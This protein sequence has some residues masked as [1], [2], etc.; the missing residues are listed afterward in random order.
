[1]GAKKKVTRTRKEGRLNLLIDPSLKEWAHG[2]ANR[3]STSISFLVVQ[4]LL[5]LKEEDS[6]PN[7]RQI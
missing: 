2:Y 4:Q 3:N 5:R 6:K 7:V 1:M